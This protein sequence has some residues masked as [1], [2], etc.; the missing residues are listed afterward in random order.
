MSRKLFCTIGGILF[1]LIALGHLL[2]IIFGWAANVAGLTV[3]MWASWVAFIVT[4]FLAFAGLRAS[5]STN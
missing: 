1:L 3:P 4:G 2:R 5:R